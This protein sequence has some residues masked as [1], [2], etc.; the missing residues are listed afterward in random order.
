MNKILFA[1]AATLITSVSIAQVATRTKHFNLEK[2][3]ALQ[4][5]DPVAYFIS[6]K[7]KKAINNLVV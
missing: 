5:Y 4:G 6:N 3:L 2:G 1:I 7:A